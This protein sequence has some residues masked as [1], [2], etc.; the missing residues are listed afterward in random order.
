M[1]MKGGNSRATLNNHT[2][3]ANLFRTLESIS[4]GHP[5][6]SRFASRVQ[7]Y[8]LLSQQ[9][10]VV[11]AFTKNIILLAIMAASSYIDGLIL[12]RITDTYFERLNSK[13]TL[14]VLLFL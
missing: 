4:I 9:F 5:K 3:K 2:E 12:L 13:L 10:H 8:Q 14:N 11:W 7:V 1:I 6:D